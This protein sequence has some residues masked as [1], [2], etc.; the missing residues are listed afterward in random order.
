M[1]NMIKVIDNASFE[2]YHLE[3][4][5]PKVSL[6][7]DGKYWQLDEPVQFCIRADSKWLVYVYLHPPYKTDLDTVPR[8][9]IFH[10]WF[11]GRTKTAALLHD[12]LYREKFDRELA[13]KLFLRAMKL[14]GVR[15]R[16]RLPIYLAVRWFG[17]SYYKFSKG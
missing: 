5:L 10:A 9:P 7:P 4:V 17:G 8:L 14:E 12:F 1:T 2:R 11:K 6:I 16:Y 3:E 15:K 13:D